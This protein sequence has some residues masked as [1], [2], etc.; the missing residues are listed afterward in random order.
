MFSSCLIF[1]MKN[2]AQVSSS[3]DFAP[4]EAI[5]KNLIN[6]SIEESQLPPRFTRSKDP[7]P[8]QRDAVPQLSDFFSPKYANEYCTAV[9]I[10]PRSPE[11][12]ENW[13]AF[14]ISDKILRWKWNMDYVH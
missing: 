8:R 3:L 14:K 10:K 6:L 2:F 11:P 1:L 5:F 7:E 4:D 12:L 13:N 9:C